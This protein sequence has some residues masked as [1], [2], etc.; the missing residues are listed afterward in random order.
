MLMHSKPSPL[1]APSHSKSPQSV[2]FPYSSLPCAVMKPRRKDARFRACI[3]WR[4]WCLQAQQ[5]GERPLQHGASP[6]SRAIS[7][8]A[9]FWTRA[10]GRALLRHRKSARASCV[11]GTACVDSARRYLLDG[12]RSPK[13]VWLA[14]LGRGPAEAHRVVHESSTTSDRASAPAGLL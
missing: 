1:V 2:P 13:A 3:L 11:A 14:E 12:L 9:G 8:F 7:V 4:R 10:V 5:Q 6:V